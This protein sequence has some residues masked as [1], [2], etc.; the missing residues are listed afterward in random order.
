MRLIS[1]MLSTVSVC[2]VGA[3]LGFAFLLPLQASAQDPKLQSYRDRLSDATIAMLDARRI[4]ESKQRDEWTDA[5]LETYLNQALWVAFY[6][7]LLQ[8]FSN[9]QQASDGADFQARSAAV[10]WPANPLR[11]WEPMKVLSVNDEFSAG[12]L[13]FQPCPRG[14]E[15]VTGG[16]I[17]FASFELSVFGTDKNHGA[18]GNTGSHP[19]NSEW[20][21]KPVGSLYSLGY[22]RESAKQ[23]YEKR[24]HREEERQKARDAQRSGN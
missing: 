1:P 23:T 13:V 14:Y 15:S 18:F 8:L 4:L 2:F 22:W 12:D 17:V 24:K 16:D 20:A 6:G 19:R 11:N 10:E 7:N 21:V 5:E 9:D 3:L